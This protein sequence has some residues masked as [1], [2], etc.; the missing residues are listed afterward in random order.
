MTASVFF[1]I[2]FYPFNLML[3]IAVFWLFSFLP[4]YRYKKAY[5]LLLF[6]L[7][8]LHII[9]IPNA[10]PQSILFI[11]IFTPYCKTIWIPKCWLHLFHLYFFTYN[12][13]SLYEACGIYFNISVSVFILPETSLLQISLWRLSPLPFRCFLQE[14]LPYHPYIENMLSAVP[15]GPILLS[16][17][18]CILLI[19][20]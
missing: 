4:A 20:I 11:T 15:N 9:Y 10:K 13:K 3:L 18:L 19:V 5:S 12:W 1:N 17:G 7:R 16:F 6:L 14:C 2:H 8:K